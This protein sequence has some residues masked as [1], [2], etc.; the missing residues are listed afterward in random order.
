[1]FFVIAL[2]THGSA[3]TSLE[4]TEV[5]ATAVVYVE[6]ILLGFHG[7]IHELSVQSECIREFHK[8]HFSHNPAHV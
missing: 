8:L 2:Q 5:V 7:F 3:K 1:M 6:Q 4:V